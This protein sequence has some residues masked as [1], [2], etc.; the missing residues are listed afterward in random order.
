MSQNARTLSL[1]ATLIVGLSGCA[2]FLV[3]ISQASWL[4]PPTRIMSAPPEEAIYGAV[5]L[6]AVAVTAWLGLT[7]ILSVVAFS[8]RIPQAIR[9][10]GRLTIAP[11]HR[12]AGRVAALALTLAGLSI[13][14]TAAGAL[15]DPPVPYQ[16]TAEQTEPTHLSS[17]ESGRADSSPKAASP[18]PMV[19]KPGA[20]TV[21][22]VPVATTPTE[23]G[24]AIP[25]PHRTVPGSGVPHFR[26]Y[27]NGTIT[28]LVEPGDHLWSISAKYLAHRLER[29]PSTDEV[30]A[31]W[32]EVVKLNRATI[33]SGDPNL[34]FP[35]EKIILP[36]LKEY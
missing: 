23:K 6:L 11:L 1:F 9:L 14:T 16:V 19:I 35:G 12:L 22:E 7:T 17:G 8:V 32:V 10:T 21:I 36:D 31:I 27:Q 13:T 34:I 18:I 20:D 29:R 26:L 33:R 4:P 2:Y 28:Y 3:R 25:V 15:A 24:A 30:Y 5:W